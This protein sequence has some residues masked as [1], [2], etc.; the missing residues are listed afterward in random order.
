MKLTSVTING[1]DES[2]ELQVLFMFNPIIDGGSGVRKI[3][4]WSDL[5]NIC[6]L[7]QIDF[8]TLMIDQNILVELEKAWGEAPG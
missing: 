6:L 5:Q 2:G 1:M 7:N 8:Q 3:H 4:S